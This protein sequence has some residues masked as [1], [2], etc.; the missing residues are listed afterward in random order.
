[1]AKKAASLNK[2]VRLISYAKMAP[3]AGTGAVRGLGT[4]SKECS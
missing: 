4:K 1:V 3:L 2:R